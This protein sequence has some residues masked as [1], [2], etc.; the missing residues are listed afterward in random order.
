MSLDLY[1]MPPKSK[2]CPTC[3][4]AEGGD[5]Y[6]SYNATHNLGRMADALGI[7][8]VCWHPDENGIKVAADLIPYLEEA[9][10]R[11]AERPDE[12]KALEPSNGWGTVAWMSDFIE[13]VLNACREMP[14]ATVEASI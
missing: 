6:R 13:N 12:M 11:L 1:I 3:G 9:Q 7:Y 8:K 14:D 2:P 5:D 4:H 10:K